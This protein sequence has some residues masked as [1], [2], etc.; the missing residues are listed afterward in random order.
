[1]EKVNAVAACASYNLGRK[2]KSKDIANDRGFIAQEFAG[3]LQQILSSEWMK[4][5]HLKVKNRT[6]RLGLI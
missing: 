1:M 4:T 6:K 2:A 3:S 5:Q